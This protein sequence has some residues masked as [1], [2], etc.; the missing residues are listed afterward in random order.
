MRLS[1]LALVFAYTCILAVGFFYYPKW[2][3]PGTE[4]TISWDVSGYYLYLPATFI[5]GDLR[6]VAFGPDLIA[7]YGPTP[8]FQQ[9]YP[10]ASGRYVLK[11]SAGWAVQ[12]LPFFALGHSMASAADEYPA[13]G[14]SYPYQLA[15]SLGA[16]FYVL[17]GLIYLRRALRCYF[18]EGVT[19]ATLLGIV[20][21]TNYF[22]Y[23]AIDGAMT[24][25]PLFTLYALLLWA[26]IHFYRQ[27]RTSYALLIGALV[28]LAALTRPTE[29]ITC[30][31]PLGWGLEVT[32]LAA[33]RERWQFWQRHGRKLGVAVVATLAVGSLQ[34]IYWKYATGDWLVYSYQDQGF[35]W[36]RP[37]LQ[38]G[39]FSFRSGWLTYTPLMWLALFG[40]YSLWRRYRSLWGICFAFTLLYIYI[41]FSWDIWWY[42][43]SLGQR[44]M[45]QTYPLL[46]FPLAAFLEWGLVLGRRGYASHKFNLRR[47]LTL[48]FILLCVYYN[49]WLTHQA[50]RGGLFAA[51]DMTRSYFWRVLGRFDRDERDL[52]LLDT[53]EDFRG[54][55]H[56]IVRLYDN[57]F[58]QSDTAMAACTL[59]PIE[60]QRSFCLHAG[61]QYGP[62]VE[63]PLAPA[64]DRWL[65]AGATFRVALKEW[66]TWRMTQL[67]VQFWRG[68]EAI[69]TRV[70][71]PP[72]LLS[73][74]ETQEIFLDTP[75]PDEP[76]DRLTV[77]FWHADGDKEI[78]IDQLY[79]ETYHD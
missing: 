14:F 22:N 71:R 48:V 31:L 62:T 13:D 76:F 44:T 21:G 54:K 78:L 36:L 27:P 1:V 40:L 10:H 30:L 29:I 53:R 59:P 79:I 51:G 6:Q 20:F 49:L 32:R 26:T 64:T 74:G 61:R 77:S 66:N 18:S 68:E 25:S 65:R 46:A 39:L 75:L 56:D 5:Y 28:G 67:I 42:G 73:D 4:A 12:F 57:N 23:A 41:A 3:K 58:E 34:L 8:D 19:A 43:G 35:S 7:R 33:W 45:V 38:G 63:L 11:Y 47:W 15:I 16:L 37:H 50:H 55:R 52:L 60:G 24:H 17:I 9:A 2:K 72:R 70:I 69:K